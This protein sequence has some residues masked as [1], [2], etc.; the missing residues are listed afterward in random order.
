MAVES[1]KVRMNTKDDIYAVRE[2]EK[3]II[4]TKG[5]DCDYYHLSYIM[6]SDLWMWNKTKLNKTR[7]LKQLQKARNETIL[8]ENKEIPYGV[9]KEEWHICE[10]T[11]QESQTVLITV[12]YLIDIWAPDWSIE[13][14]Q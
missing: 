9:L 4:L 14:L 7:M 11:L 8:Y 5:Q 12:M 1:T 2:E 3:S 6:Y 10:K 13:I